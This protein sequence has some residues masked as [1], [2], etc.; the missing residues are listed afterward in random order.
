MIDWHVKRV[1]VRANNSLSVT[2]SDGT[3]GI[4]QFELSRFR[5][6]FAPLRDPAVFEN[7]TIEHGALT[8]MNGTI[9]LAPDAMY[10]RVKKD[11][12]WT[13]R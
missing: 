4:V 1:E 10:D 5:D 12:R 8:W 9:D 3:S 7:V 2:F 6:A 11:G 13:L